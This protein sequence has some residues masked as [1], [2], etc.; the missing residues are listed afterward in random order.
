MSETMKGKILQSE[1]RPRINECPFCGGEATVK[2]R[3]FAMTPRKYRVE[4]T[5]CGASGKEQEDIETA[6]SEWNKR[7]T[8]YV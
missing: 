1:N 8:P 5:K 3:T 4:C 7:G 2:T 6:V